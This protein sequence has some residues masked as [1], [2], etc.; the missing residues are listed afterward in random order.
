MGT[1]AI[2]AWQCDRCRGLLVAI[3]VADGATPIRLACRAEGC[4]GTAISSGY[5]RPPIPD[6]IKTALAWE[7]RRATNTELKRWRREN[8]G[9]FQHCSAGGLV[10][11]PLT[12]VGAD[13]ATE[14]HHFIPTSPTRTER[15]A[16]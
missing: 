15:P 14:R 5:P 13:L 12:T 7:W 11:G 9:M 2:N 16:P 6:A 10:L 3:H 8:P 1:G 4:D